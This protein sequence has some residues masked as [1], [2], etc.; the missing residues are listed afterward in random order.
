MVVLIDP[1]AN[2]N[3]TTAPIRAKVDADRTL[4]KPR[5]TTIP[6]PVRAYTDRES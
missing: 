1:T 4:G 2:P 5:A 6:N 3:I